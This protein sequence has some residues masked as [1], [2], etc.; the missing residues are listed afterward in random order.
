MNLGVFYCTTESITIKQI[1]LLYSPGHA[2][3]SDIISLCYKPKIIDTL[4]H[5]G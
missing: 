3:D 4:I 5:N 1:E 2:F